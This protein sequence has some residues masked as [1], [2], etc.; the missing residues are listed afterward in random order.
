M[1]HI[2]GLME[3]GNSAL[4]GHAPFW[5]RQVNFAERSFFSYA[6]LVR[7]SGLG[8]VSAETAL[9]VP[10]MRRMQ[11][12]SPLGPKNFVVWS[13]ASR[14]ENCSFFM[15]VSKNDALEE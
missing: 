10:G 8:E 6:K 2:L 12:Y 15:I 13:S 14:N 3:E 9:P 11:R 7:N 4:A 5:K 1:E